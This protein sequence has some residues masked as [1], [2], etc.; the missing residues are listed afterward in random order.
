LAVTAAETEATNAADALLTAESNVTEARENLARVVALLGAPTPP[1]A[2]VLPGAPATHPAT[3]LP[4]APTPPPV[5]RPRRLPPVVTRVSG[6]S[7]PTGAVV[8]PTPIPPSDIFKEEII[9][10]HHTTSTKIK[11]II[12]DKLKITNPLPNNLDKKI[13]LFISNYIIL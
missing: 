3:V 13:E 5:I 2:T 10:R 4:G 11:Q 7:V 1:P 6:P 8:S 9:T 12:S